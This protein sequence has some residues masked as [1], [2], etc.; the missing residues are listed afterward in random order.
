VVGV[1]VICPV[2]EVEAKFK[3]GGSDP[4]SDHTYVPTPPFA[5]TPAEY[6][7]PMVPPGSELVVIASAVKGA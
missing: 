5:F 7:V 4:D 1:P 2:G 3:P 6:A